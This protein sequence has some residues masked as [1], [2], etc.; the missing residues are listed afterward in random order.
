MGFIYEFAAEVGNPD[1]TLSI[2]SP[3]SH[4]LLSFSN[5]PFSFV[6][7]LSMYNCKEITNAPMSN[8]IPLQI[9][10]WMYFEIRILQPQITMARVTREDFFFS[11]EE[12]GGDFFWKYPLN[13]NDRFTSWTKLL[14]RFLS[15][16][17]KP[18]HSSVWTKHAYVDIKKKNFVSQYS[19]ISRKCV[20]NHD[21][22]FRHPILCR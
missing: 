12:I 14:I 15:V 10:Q 11:H 3:S 5:L 20:V 2:R 22:K 21:G 8:C 19:E 16:A 18:L 9:P 7:K 6:C 1:D 13:S 17:S 4:F